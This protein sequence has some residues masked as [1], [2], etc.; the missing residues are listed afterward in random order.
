M[1]RK[2][3]MLDFDN[4]YE[5]IDRLWPV[6]NRVLKI[7]AIEKNAMIDVIKTDEDFVALKNKIEILV[8]DIDP[9]RL[10]TLSSFI[11]S[12]LRVVTKQP[13]VSTPV[14]VAPLV[15][16]P[17]EVEILFTEIFDAWPQNDIPQNEKN[18]KIAFLDASK[19]YS[20]EE[21]KKACLLYIE[22]MNDPLKAAVH[23]FGIKRFV[24]DESILSDWIQK[25]SVEI[26]SYDRSFFEAAYSWY[27]E[28]SGKSDI[29][30]I[31][32]S[33]SFYKRFVKDVD[34]VDF[35]CAVKDYADERK[36]EIS[37]KE[38]Q[39]EMDGEKYTKKFCN[40]IRCWK[41]QKRS[42]YLASLL[43]VPLLKALKKREIKYWV[44]Y[45]E[46]HFMGALQWCCQHGDQEKR[47]VVDAVTEML[48][49]ICKYLTS[50]VNYDNLTIKTEPDYTLVSEVIVAAKEL[51]KV[52]KK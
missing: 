32:D 42:G 16:V 48:E 2:R 18:A 1:K 4:Y 25:S 31:S 20:L 46:E 7:K 44:V 14:I 45:P 35:L 29:K 12:A 19:K 47:T 8:E 17:D 22:E 51:A 27:P 9:K 37:L 34:T 21:L 40:F 52:V 28:F 33:L 3:K 23:T 50:G 41:Q 39:G 26:Q 10:P 6:K 49:C 24:S 15:T 5:Q 43:E 38:A 11:S 30:N 13:I 36:D